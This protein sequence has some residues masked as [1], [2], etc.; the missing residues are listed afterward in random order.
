M[1]KMES[2]ARY[3]SVA[4]LHQTVHIPSVQRDRAPHKVGAIK[5]YILDR[6][7]SN[8][9]VVLG[10]L[11]FA[12]LKDVLYLVDGQ[13]RYSALQE[14]YTESKIQV[15]FCAI[16]YP[17][18]ESSELVEIFKAVNSGTPVPAYLLSDPLSER[19]RMYKVVEQKLQQRK[20]FDVHHKTRPYVHNDDFMEAFTQSKLAQLCTTAVELVHSCDIVSDIL[21]AH[22]GDSKYCKSQKITVN[23][24]AK[25]NE[26]DNYLGL[27]RNYNYMN[28]DAIL[29][30]VHSKLRNVPQEA[31]TAD[32]KMEVVDNSNNRHKFSASQRQLI[33]HTYIGPH[34]GRI[35]CPLCR[36]NNIEPL[37]YVVGHVVSLHNG[38]T[39]DINN[40]R[41]ICSMCN[42][43]MG[44]RDMDLAR[45]TLEGL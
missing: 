4:E 15:P 13:H 34:R 32:V 29:Q 19:T 21:K 28:D 39:N 40:V 11:I 17:T 14:L 10:A 43:S 22:T 38:G 7:K 18:V 42:S 16:V 37:N 26:W 20:G 44:V 9:P 3:N 6:I 41:P 45:Y 1:F 30:V 2:L 24:L 12:N 33:W 31:H 27:D 8:K 23:M 5:E 36:V 25:C 35:L